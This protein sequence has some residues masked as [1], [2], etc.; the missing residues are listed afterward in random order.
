MHDRSFKSAK[1]VRFGNSHFLHIFAHSLFLKERLCDRFFI[2]LLKSA[3]KSAIALLKRATKK[4]NRTIAL[5]KRATKNA[6]AQ[7]HF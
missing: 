7:L 6:I 2:M 1:K 5:L 3:T 4:C